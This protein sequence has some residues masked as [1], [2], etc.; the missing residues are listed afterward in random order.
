MFEVLEEDS[1]LRN[2]TTSYLNAIYKR[3]ESTEDKENLRDLT[4]VKLKKHMTY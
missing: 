2:R 4:L 3:G 1:T